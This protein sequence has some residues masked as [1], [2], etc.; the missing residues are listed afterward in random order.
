MLRGRCDDERRKEGL[1]QQHSQAVQGT[2]HSWLAERE[3]TRSGPSFV[4]YDFLTSSSLDWMESTTVSR[5]LTCLATR[6]LTVTSTYADCESL[7][8]NQCARPRCTTREL[9][10]AHTHTASPSHAR[11]PRALSTSCPQVVETF[12]AT[13]WDATAPPAGKPAAGS[14]LITHTAA[15]RRFSSLIRRRHV[16]VTPSSRKKLDE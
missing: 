8:R 10:C 7:T 13:G 16:S 15:P 5:S 3:P 12:R 6:L 4:G 1:A 2:G 11:G 14:V 9:V